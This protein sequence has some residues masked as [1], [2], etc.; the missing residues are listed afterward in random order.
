[1][2]APFP[3]DLARAVADQVVTRVRNE[4]AR[5]E[6]LA[7]SAEA[8]QE[9]EEEGDEEYEGFDPSVSIDTML[10]SLTDSDLD[11]QVKKASFF[12]IPLRPGI[13]TMC[14]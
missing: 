10:S 6:L 7:E 11:L 1:M 3:G 14:T 9:E 13:K 12:N 2:L 4:V 5:E 8:S